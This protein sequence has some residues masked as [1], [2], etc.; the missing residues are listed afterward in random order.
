M[1]CPAT[2]HKGFA[3]HYFQMVNI[4]IKTNIVLPTGFHYWAKLL[5]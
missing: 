4:M 3:A 5:D 1:E 2:N